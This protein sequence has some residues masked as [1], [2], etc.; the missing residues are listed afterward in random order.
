MNNTDNIFILKNYGLIKVKNV[1]CKAS[2]PINAAKKLAKYIIKK[3]HN[4]LSFTIQN[5]HTKKVYEYTLRS[6]L[7][8]RKKTI[9]RGGNRKMPFEYG[10]QVLL[11]IQLSTISK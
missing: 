3:S 2:T 7:V 10:M 5:K 6:S 11:R 1:A 9:K 8:K 4:N